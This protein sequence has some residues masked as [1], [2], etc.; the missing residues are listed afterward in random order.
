[1]NIGDLVKIKNLTNV[2]YAVIIKFNKYVDMFMIWILSLET[3]AMF[4]EYELEVINECR[5]FNIY[6]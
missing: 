6:E 5:R 3:E 1:M 2:E 4:Y